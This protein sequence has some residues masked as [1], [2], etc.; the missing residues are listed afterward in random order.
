MSKRSQ[1]N[2]ILLSSLILYFSFWPTGIEAV[3]WNAPEPPALSGVYQPNTKLD[4]IEKIG[5]NHGIAG[6]DVAIDNEGRIY[7]GYKDGRIV[8]FQA[9]GLQ[10]KELINTGG[11][12]L[13]LD[14]DNHGN[15]IIADADRGLL[16]LSPEG[17]LEVLSTGTDSYNLVFTDDVDVAPDGQ[18]YFSDASSKHNRHNL[19]E[20]MIEHRPHGLLLHYNPNDKTTKILMRDL[21]FANGI[22]V[23]PDNTFLLVV[24]T[25]S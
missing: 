12:P 18:I 16:L 20:D 25:D 23:S 13:G 17:K 9:D 21:Y 11:R 22:A 24:E 6:E 10:P 4:S 1:L 3:A 7:T 19:K 14:F 8:R 2:L 15:L 5:L